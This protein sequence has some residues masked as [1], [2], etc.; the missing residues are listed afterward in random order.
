MKPLTPNI[1]GTN[2]YS[3]RKFL[4]LLRLVRS[5]ACIEVVM[6]CISSWPGWRALETMDMSVTYIMPLISAL[7]SALW[8]WSDGG[9][10]GIIKLASSRVTGVGI[11]SVVCIRRLVCKQSK[12]WVKLLFIRKHLVAQGTRNNPVFFVSATFC[13]NL[14]RAVHIGGCEQS[15]NC[16]EGNP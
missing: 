15:V 8:F 2:V 9:L 11:A 14:A 7:T 3:G 4:Y 13:K 5:L 10:P 6:S 12:S 16:L 1:K